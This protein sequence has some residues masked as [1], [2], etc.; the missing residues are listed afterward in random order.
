MMN[1][2]TENTLMGR[3][4]PLGKAYPLFLERLFLL[5]A[6]LAFVFFSPDVREAVGHELLGPV[7]AYIAFPLAL[8]ALVELAGRW[9]QQRMAS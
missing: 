8:L 5:A 9:L 4:E 2:P 7:V 1:M 6:I 3:E